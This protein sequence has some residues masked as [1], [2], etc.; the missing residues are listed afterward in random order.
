MAQLYL[1]T[2]LFLLISAAVILADTYGASLPVLFN[3]KSQ[4]LSRRVYRI[5]GIFTG[6]ALAVGLCIFPMG[7]G[8]VVIGDPLPVVVLILIETRLVVPHGKK[9]ILPGN[10]LG[11]L[12]LG[13]AVVHFIMPKIVIL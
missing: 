13:T 5:L 10:W 2:E 8:P 9:T 4:F 12:S 6:L 11:F 1:L 7:A 3:I